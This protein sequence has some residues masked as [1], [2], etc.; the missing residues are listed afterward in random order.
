M[1]FF[2]N[3]ARRFKKMPLI[4]L[5]YA[6][7]PDFFTCCRTPARDNIAR[8]VCSSGYTSDLLL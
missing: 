7:M 2:H 5:A 4:M 6:F 8:I 1:V 3:Y